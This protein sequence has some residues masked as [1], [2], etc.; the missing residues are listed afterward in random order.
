MTSASN[1][2]H[3][4]LPIWESV[5]AAYPLAIENFLGLRWATV[6]VLAFELFPAWLRLTAPLDTT[7]LM[8]ANALAPILV[9]PY[10]VLIHRRVILGELGRSYAGAA[11]SMRAVRFAGVGLGL[12]LLGAVG[13]LLFETGIPGVGVIGFAWVLAWCVVAVRVLLAF[14]AIATE[15]S[16]EPLAAS[17]RTT[18]GSFW[19]LFWAFALAFVPVVPVSIALFYL[20]IP[21]RIGGD[22]FLSTFTTALFVTL[23]SLL[24]RT[25]A[26]WSRA[27]A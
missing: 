21:V 9:A 6:V 1:P 18:S 5:K 24:Y 16:S 11:L 15:A 8:V 3:P 25:R 10:G 14:P 27:S 17:W 23:A 20:P 4:A 19:R 12:W 26:E 2:A 22:A 13:S 7:A